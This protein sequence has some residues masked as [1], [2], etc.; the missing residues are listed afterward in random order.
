M[1]SSCLAFPVGL[2]GLL[3][4]RTRPESL[5]TNLEM[6][7][8]IDGEE[9]VKVSGVNASVFLHKCVDWCV[10]ALSPALSFICIYACSFCRIPWMPC[11]TSWWN[12]PRLT[13]TTSSCLTH[14]WVC[15]V[16]LPSKRLC[17]CVP[18]QQIQLISWQAACMSIWHIQCD[19]LVSTCPS[20][21]K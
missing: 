3:K 12:T 8:M 15:G 5:N 11:S 20:F 14:W 2:L 6:L 17:V 7:K 16:L 4:W 10:C 19:I 21:P 18:C 1:L 13:T 9:V